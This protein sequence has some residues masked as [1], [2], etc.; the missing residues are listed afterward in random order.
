MAKSRTCQHTSL[1]TRATRFSHGGDLQAGRQLWAPHCGHKNRRDFR[2]RW[3]DGQEL[4]HRTRLSLRVRTPSLRK[5]HPGRKLSLCL[6]Q[7]SGTTTGTS[8]PKRSCSLLFT[9][10][11]SNPQKSDITFKMTSSLAGRAGPVPAVAGWGR[12]SPGEPTAPAVHT[13][14]R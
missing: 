9:S 11:L 5:N 2:A 14:K 8:A 13:P 3:P 10:P 7:F 12:L 6:V 4:V 1:D